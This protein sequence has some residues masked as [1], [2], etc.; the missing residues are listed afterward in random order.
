M[1]QLL[2]INT[3]VGFV[4][5][6]I[7]YFCQYIAF[8]QLT[9]ADL[10]PTKTI[11]LLEEQYRQE[12]YALVTQTA[13]ECL[14]EMQPVNLPV[15]ATSVEKIKYYLVLSCMKTE[16]PG[17]ED[18]VLNFLQA[19]PSVIYR[20]RVSFALAHHYFL[21]NKLILAIPYYEAS[22]VDFLSNEEIADKNFELAYCYFNSRQ[23]DKAEPLFSSIKEIKEGKYY[24]SGNYYYGLLAYNDKKF[25][26]ALQCFENIK[27]DKTY[28]STIPFYI[29]ET[30]YFGG[31]RDKA[32]AVA[33]ATIKKAEKTF[34]ENELH[35]LAAQCLFE[36]E[37]YAESLPYFDFFYENN[38]KIRR[39]DLYKMAYCYYRVNDWNNAEEKFK[40]LSNA[41][42]SLGQTAMYLLG[43]CC[44]KT[45]DKA[46]ARSAFGI[47]AD[48]AFNLGQQEASLMLYAMLSF[49]LGFKDEAARA[50]K[51]LLSIFPR[52]QYKDEAHT[53]LSDLLI[54]I[55]NYEEA[56]RY[57]DLV[58]VREHD[59]YAVYQKAAFGYGLQQ[60]RLGNFER[61]DSML[62]AVLRYPADG[63]YEAA[64]YFWKGELAFRLRKYPEAMAY[65]QKFF[66]KKNDFAK[67]EIL[68]PEA[69]PQHAYLNM[70]F[71][72]MEVQNYSA[73]QS[74]FNKAQQYSKNDFKTWL[75]A[76]LREA[77]A[78]FMQ[79]NY[80]RAIILYNKIIATDT[81][82]EDYATLQKAIILGLQRK[83]DDK[84]DLLQEFCAKK[85][86]STYY[87]NAKYELACTYVELKQYLTALK[88]LQELKDQQDRSFASKAW[89]KTGD[90]YQLLKDN[91]KAI[92]AYKQ[93]IT[94]FPASDERLP[95]LDAVRMLYIQ[96]GHAESYAKLLKDNHLPPGDSS[97]MD[98]T[99]YYSAVGAYN[100]G[101]WQE[102]NS[103][104][105]EYLQLY[106]NGIF[107]IKAHYYFGET[108]YQLKNFVGA[109]ENFEWVLNQPLNDY[110][111]IAALKAAN[112]AFEWKEFDKSL[113]CFLFLRRN[114]QNATTV[115]VVYKGIMK[116]LFY[117]GKTDE[118]EKYADSLIHT[119]GV[120]PEDINE[121]NFIKAHLYRMKNNTKAAM[122]LYKQLKN[123]K[124][125]EIA[126]ASRYYI[127][128]ILMKQDDF[129]GAEEAA[130]ETIRLSAGNDYW[131]VKSY[132]LLGDLL[133]KQG[134]IFNAKATY[135]GIVKHTKIVDLKQEATSKLNELKKQERQKS[136]LK[137][138]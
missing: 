50:L 40:L 21:N 38:P 58:K 16:A 96:A 59:F 7:F 64:A 72:S 3:A 10:T 6:V 46:G 80:S 66:S 31:Q 65:N 119:P 115:F 85:Q 89:M 81:G 79:K 4:L 76:S 97:L 25:D 24:K 130:K 123:A 43:D 36:D 9:E 77:D 107:A 114:L 62:S 67:A 47:C 73:A 126:A 129:T 84:V 104:F 133:F 102:A 48:H 82:N 103:G 132:L 112:V 127:A 74:F 56:F 29:A 69:S 128:N 108:N 134:D 13:R 111:E 120:T 135:D 86:H 122:N 45:F 54:K 75:I 110:S 14:T 27:N 15:N 137:D 28:R 17:W 2:R 131:I 87:L 90:V 52:T 39:E 101:K 35:L 93:V 63:S 61:A 109:L 118:A 60:F 92:S 116:S 26:E 99:F 124:N 51:S 23:F 33:V 1:F 113:T 71:A 37:R 5:T 94:G 53:L 91:D 41:T 55:Q 12:H 117:G 19:N 95:A 121:A 49:E 70:G 30:Y 20:Q 88:Y 100:S 105:E 34:F 68:S 11:A 78:V 106:P 57:L 136:K 44:L 8:G 98:S 18:S 83:K 125:G 22:G 32:L 42:D 138:E